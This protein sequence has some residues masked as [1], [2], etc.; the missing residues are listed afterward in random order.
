MLTERA[1]TAESR[2]SSVQMKDTPERSVKADTANHR[3]K[4]QVGIIVPQTYYSNRVAPRGK[5][6]P[7][8]GFVR[9]FFSVKKYFIL[10]FKKEKGVVFIWQS[11]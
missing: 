11:Q 8:N 10:L 3:Y 4:I 7:D 2:L 6:V 1:V 9:D 5:L